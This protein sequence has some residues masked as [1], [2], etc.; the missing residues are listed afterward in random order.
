MCHIVSD[1]FKSFLA[2][3]GPHAIRILAYIAY[4]ADHSPRMQISEG[5]AEH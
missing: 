3:F 2:G 5:D 1:S 4:H